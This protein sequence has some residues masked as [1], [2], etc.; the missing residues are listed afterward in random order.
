[1]SE[2]TQTYTVKMVGATSLSA[3]Q[4][5]AAE[6][7]FRM[8]LEFG[9]GGPAYVVPALQACM[10]ARSLIEGLPAEERTDAE[11]RAEREVI[12][13]W[14]NAEDRAIMSALKPLNTAGDMDEV[15]FEISV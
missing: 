11:C 4:R 9:V 5:S 3:D 2:Q 1:M 14:E 15:R 7:R 12:A 13:L 6:L 10:L 8:A